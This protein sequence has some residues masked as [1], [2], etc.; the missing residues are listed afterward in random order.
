[1]SFSQGTLPTQGSNCILCV[2]CI[3]GGFFT[4]TAPGKPLYSAWESKAKGCHFK[5]NFSDVRLPDNDKS[6]YQGVQRVAGA[7]HES[8]T[9][10]NVDLQIY[11]FKFTENWKPE[12]KAP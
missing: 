10:N 7:E 3:T 1:M 2:S 11:R 6:F 12:V 9:N 8:K 5:D 4:I